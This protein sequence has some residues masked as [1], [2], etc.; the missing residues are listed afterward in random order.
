MNTASYSELPAMFQR[1]APPYLAERATGDVVVSAE[2]ASLHLADGRTLLD[3]ASGGFGYGVSPVV[4]AVQAQ[5]RRLPLS[6]RVLISRTLAELVVELDKLCP[7]PLSVSYVCNSGDEAFEGA[8]KLAK[9]LNPR[10]NRL[11]VVAGSRPGS[12][13]YGTLLAGIG[14][15][16]LDALGME[17]VPIR[18]N[19]SASLAGSLDRSTLAVVYEPVIRE[20]GLC[21]LE[22]AFL[23]EMRR[24]CDTHGCL[25]I[26]SELHTGLGFAGTPL[27]ISL[28]GVVPDALVLGDALGGGQIGVG[29][30]VT[31][32][33]INDAVYGG[34]NPSLHGSTTGGNPASCVAATVALR[35]LARERIA[36]RQEGLGRAFTERFA[37]RA[38][39]PESLIRNYQVC[40]GLVSVELPGPAPADRLWRECL[41]AG[42][43]LQRPRDRWLY[44][45]PPLTVSERE[46]EQVLQRLQ[47][48]CER[49]GCEP[50]ALREVV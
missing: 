42:L 44:L 34:R 37:S 50:A 14:A 17:V 36:Q 46:W 2:G 45:A 11:L 4:E 26:A 1:H 25:M 10:R 23:T 28:T 8:L 6:N 18:P 20:R 39:N 31:S 3:A 24:G 38:A 7:T 47:R 29:V 41:G 30:Y 16:Y 12:L 35:H 9:G 19:D 48:G 13:S 49:A 5:L 32:K 15:G 33:A 40:G 27:G 22:A 43:L 21:R